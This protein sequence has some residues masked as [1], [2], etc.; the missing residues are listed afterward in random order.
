M[1]IKSLEVSE[2]K[3]QSVYENDEAEYREEEEWYYDDAELIWKR[4]PGGN[5]LKR[6]FSI[7]IPRQH[8]FAS[9]Y[10]V[11]GL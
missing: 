4:K 2:V 3:I 5:V 8:V 7:A 1:K 10:S 9:N 6:M 11:A